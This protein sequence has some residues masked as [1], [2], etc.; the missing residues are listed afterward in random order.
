MPCI[1]DKQSQGIPLSRYVDRRGPDRDAQPWSGGEADTSE[2]KVII[3]WAATVTL[4]QSTLY[5]VYEERSWHLLV[6]PLGR[7]QD[8]EDVWGCAK[9]AQC[10]VGLGILDDASTEARAALPEEIRNE[11][12]RLYE[13]AQHRATFGPHQ[14]RLP[15]TP[16]MRAA[17]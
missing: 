3:Q 14:L 9:I 8:R 5:L 7:H 1:L 17:S 2:D 13:D 12:M 11:V 10:L 16:M 6:I 4:Y 15:F